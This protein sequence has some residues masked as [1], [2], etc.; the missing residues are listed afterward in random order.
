MTKKSIWL[1]LMLL[2]VLPI[3]GCGGE[4]TRVS[5][6]VTFSDGAPV[7]RGNVVFTDGTYSATGVIR[8]DGSF[9][10]TSLNHDDG[11]RPGVYTVILQR[12]W[13]DEYDDDGNVIRVDPF[14][15]DSRFSCREASGLTF[16]IEAG[17]R[18]VAN[19]VV[20]RRE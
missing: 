5:G 3:I 11:A 16:T 13:S 2:F 7:T 10:L 4:F 1:P 8:S 6:T 14:E 19:F 15:V 17:K 12:N 18:N 9:V 20:E